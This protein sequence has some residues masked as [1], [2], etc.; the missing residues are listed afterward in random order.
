MGEQVAGMAA[1]S[2]LCDAV[3]VTDESLCQRRTR[4]DRKWC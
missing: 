1:V 4:I 3:S 2:S